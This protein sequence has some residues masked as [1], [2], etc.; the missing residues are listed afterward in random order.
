MADAQKKTYVLL[1]AH[2]WG[3]GFAAAAWK[4]GD[5]RGMIMIVL[6]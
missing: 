3:G 4:M 6:M 2:V 1:P 5:I